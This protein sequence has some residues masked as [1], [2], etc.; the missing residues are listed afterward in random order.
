MAELSQRAR[1]VSPSLTLEITA[2][3]KK[4][5]AEGQPVVSFGAGEP[6]FNT[7]E[8]IVQAA[9]SALDAGFTKYTPASGTD[10]LKAAI[11]EKLKNDNGLS[12]ELQNVVVSNGAKHSL[13][14]AFSAIVN[15]GDEV[16][17]PAP[18][19]L[20]YPELI[21]L[22]DGVPVF[23]N[24]KPENDFKLTAN[25]LK[26]AITPRTKALVLNNPC[27]PTGAV[28]SESE[29]KKLAEVLENT[30]IY[31][32]S[33]EIYEKLVYEG[34][35]CYSI[36]AYSPAI[37][38]RTI[39]V[40]GVSK[41]YAM[42]GWRIGYTA[43]NAAVAKAMGSIQSHVTSNPNSIAQY[44]AAEAYRHN[45]GE[46]FLSRMR[47]TFDN[48]RKIMIDGIAAIP[49]LKFIYPQGAF[50]VMIDIAGILGK[51]SPSGKRLDSAFTVANELL[52]TQLVAAIPCESFG[53]PG[54]LRLSYAIGEEDIRTGLERIAAF[55]AAL[56]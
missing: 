22:C 32:I 14:N 33:D 41:T 43:S 38:D 53:A 27:N 16:I 2:K 18:Y 19:W 30:D 52:D 50:Y 4:M 12:Y 39:V 36:A 21:K 11:V 17:V 15:A 34:D 7:P 5:K 47:V 56:K 29:I 55:V 44:A 42:T 23:V 26:S 45:E 37:K 49:Q 54:Y 31:I 40:N 46:R 25:E 20:T 13:Y 6:D 1:R 51:T 9:K 35:A 24:T 8:Y 48:R 3:A 10:A 28:Y